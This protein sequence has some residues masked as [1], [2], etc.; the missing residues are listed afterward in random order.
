MIL[1]TVFALFEIHLKFCSAVVIYAVLSRDNFCRKFTHF[2]VENFQ[3]LESASVKKG[4]NIRYGF[5]PL[6]NIETI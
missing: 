2:G 4:T 6:A 1:L 5:K 3:A